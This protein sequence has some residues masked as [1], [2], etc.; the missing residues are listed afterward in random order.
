[1]VAGVPVSLQGVDGLEV[2]ELRSLADQVRDKLKSVIVVLGTVKAD[3]ASLLVAVTKDLSARFPAGELIKPLAAE[4]GGT[5]GGRP[6]MAQD[7][8]KKEDERGAGVAR[9]VKGREGR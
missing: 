4:I 7:G 1:M 5:G 3:K 8:G 6:G 9:A 2:N